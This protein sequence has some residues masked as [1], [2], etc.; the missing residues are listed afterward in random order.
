MMEEKVMKTEMETVKESN[1]E[2][3]TPNVELVRE[4]PVYVNYGWGKNREGDLVLY[5][6]DLHEAE[7]GTHWTAR[8]GTYVEQEWIPWV[9]TVTVIYSDDNGVLLRIKSYDPYDE[10]VVIEMV[11]VELHR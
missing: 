10:E 3:N 5:A 7:V 1:A 4:Q 6:R 9:K 8:D 2:S 11:Y